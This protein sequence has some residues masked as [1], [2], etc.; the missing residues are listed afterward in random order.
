MNNKTRND[1]ASYG[2]EILKYAV[3]DVLYKERASR[4]K[5]SLLRQQISQQLDLPNPGRIYVSNAN[6]IGCILAHLYE[7]GYVEDTGVIVGESLR[8][9]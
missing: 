1:F 4:W 2:L 3:L 8:K 9:E 7:A 5:I 6:L